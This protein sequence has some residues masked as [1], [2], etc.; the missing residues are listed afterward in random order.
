MSTKMKHH[1]DYELFEELGRGQATIVYRGH[2]LT[3]GRDV[4]VKE[5]NE[6]VI[7]QDPNRKNQFLKEAQF[8]AQFEHENI[9]RVYTVDKQRNWII[10]EMM[11]ATLASQILSKGLEPDLVRSVLRQSLRAL[12]FLHRKQKVHAAVRPSNLL[13]NEEGFVKLSDFE[14]T[15]AEGELRIPICGKKYLSPELIRTEFGEFGPAVDFY[16]LGFTALE[17]LFGEKFDSLFP[18]TGEGAINT[19]IAWMRWHSSEDLL[20][21]AKELDRNIPDDVAQVIDLMLVKQVSGRPQSAT[22]ILNILEDRPLER[23]EVK[24]A[25]EQKPRNSYVAS[26][27]EVG[28]RAAKITSSKQKNKSTKPTKSTWDLKQLSERLK[29]PVVFI[30]FAGAV[31]AIFILLFMFPSGAMSAPE[32]QV[33]AKEIPVEAP[34]A[35][36]VVTVLVNPAYAE[37]VIN[38]QGVSCDDGIAEVEVLENENLFL[39]I[40]LEDFA[41]FEQGYSW[42]DLQKN[43]FRIFVELEALLTSPQL[44]EGLVATNDSEVDEQTGLPLRARSTHFSSDTAMDFVLVGPTRQRLGVDAEDRFPWE[45]GSSEYELTQPF[46]VAVTETTIAQFSHF[47]K[48]LG[49]DVIDSPWMLPAEKWNESNSAI[50]ITNLLP[51]TNM[52]HAQAAEFASW[53]GGRL[54]TPDE[55]ETAV[56]S[57]ALPKDFENSD[58]SQLFRGVEVK[59]ISVLNGPRTGLGLINAIGNASEWCTNSNGDAIVKGCSYATPV[60]NHV[61]PSWQSVANLNGEWDIGI[62]VIVPVASE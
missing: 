33:V 26:V 49:T 28:S 32:K 34:S 8:L 46:Y 5:L 1:P 22:E 45:S 59:P 10:M 18:G 6:E 29:K 20:P 58:E 37:I 51:V 41:P 3:L 12:D 24:T 7:G 38:N 44:P 31:C 11:N 4:A 55:W 9:L 47:Y 61:R 43:N 25:E 13:I 50:D 16:N 62:R 54:P 60:G 36:E 40:S 53:L 2:D 52:S 39:Q 27:R 17:L 56:R 35:K 48:S 21:P 42:S 30:P 57:A 14:E 23:V 19:D 15:D